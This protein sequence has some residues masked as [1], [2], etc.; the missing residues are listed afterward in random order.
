MDALVPADRLTLEA[1]KM[2][3]EDFLQQNAFHRDRHLSPPV[4]QAVTACW[5]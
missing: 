2:I 4:R 1:A 3:R 5:S